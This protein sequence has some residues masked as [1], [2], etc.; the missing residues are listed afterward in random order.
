MTIGN[1]HLLVIRASRIVE[2]STIKRRGLA[3]GDGDG[4][5]VLSGRC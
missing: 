2:S 3:D 4:L 5:A 1:G